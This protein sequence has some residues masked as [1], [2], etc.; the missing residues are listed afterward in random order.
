M[1][2]DIRP[3][4]EK[5]AV[6]CGGSVSVCVRD[7]L[8]AFDFSFN[9]EVRQRAAST[10]KVPILVEGLRQVRDGHL[11]LDSEFEVARAQCCLGAGVI[12]H[13]HDGVKVTLK[14]LLTL[15][16]IVSDNTATN[17]LIDILGMDRVNANMRGLGYAGTTLKRKMYDWGAL[18][19]GRDNFIVACEAADLL[20]RVA[21]REALGGKWDEM[22]LAIMRKQLFCDKLGLFLPKGILA[23]KTGH[24]PG[25]ENDCGVVTTDKFCYSIAVFTQDAPVPGEAKVAIGRISR[26]VYAAVCGEC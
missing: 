12:N 17:V 4:V 19:G 26:V 10:I 15:M 9:D 13:L 25:V 24:V 16:I 20:A 18:A 11:A 14:D 3:E 8:N 7:V 22:V 5:L 6:A 21:R 1:R 2:S 23:N